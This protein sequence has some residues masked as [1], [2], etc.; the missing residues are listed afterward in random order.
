MP[1]QKSKVV[2]SHWSALWYYRLS[3]MELLP[4]PYTCEDCSLDD[5]SSSLNRLSDKSLRLLSVSTAEFAAHGIYVEDDVRGAA[6]MFG[7]GRRAEA[8]AAA[9]ESPHMIPLPDGLDLLVGAGAHRVTPE[10]VR[11]HQCGR[12][13]PAGSLR[14][15]GAGL[16]VVAP[17][18]MFVQVAQALS[19]PHLVAALA[20]ELAGSYALLPAGMI[21]CKKILLRGESPFDERGYLRGDGYC[22]TLPLTTVCKLRG[23]VESASWVGGTKAA[24]RGLRAAVDGSA[25]PLETVIDIS[26]ALP[27]SWGGAGCG[28]P[29]ANRDVPLNDEGQ[30]ITGK[31]K[32]IADALFTSRNGKRIDVEPGDKDWHSGKDA[33]VSDN[34]RRLALERQKIEVIVVPWQTFKDPHAWMHVCKRV[35][36]HLGRNYHV[37]SDRMLERWTR[38]HE[39]FCDTGLLKHSFTSR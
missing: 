2:L 30:R 39:D 9:A 3:S 20:T 25:S 8:L 26:L 22:E 31:G 29:G 6:R 17:E 1:E 5:T 32:V 21:C 7:Q 37:P 18:L 38:V 10:G 35:A 36:C 33:M 34:S 23:F 27:R 11:A 12:E 4:R 15:I 19:A 14:Q 16:Y 28:L 24:G 13:L